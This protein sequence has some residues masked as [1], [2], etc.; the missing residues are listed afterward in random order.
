[1]MLYYIIESRTGCK[2]GEYSEFEHMISTCIVHYYTPSC[3]QFGAVNCTM[4][5]AATLHACQVS[6]ESC[7]SKPGLFQVTRRV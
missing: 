5:P 6:F 1:M 3:M 7:R 4:A 2:G